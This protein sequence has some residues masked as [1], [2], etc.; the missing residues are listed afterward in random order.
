VND[1]DAFVE[2]WKGDLFIDVM[3]LH[4]YRVLCEGGGAYHYYFCPGYGP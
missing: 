2:V 4:E 3:T 1:G